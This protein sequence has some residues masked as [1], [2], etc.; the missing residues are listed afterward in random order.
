ML[1][2]SK[3]VYLYPRSL[4]ARHAYMECVYLLPQWCIFT[5]CLT[6]KE[7]LSIEISQFTV[8]DQDY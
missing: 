2:I 7:P 3:A 1:E 4:L 8:D 6:L 5:I